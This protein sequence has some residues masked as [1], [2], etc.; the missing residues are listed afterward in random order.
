MVSECNFCGAHM[1]EKADGRVWCP[2]HAA[3]PALLEALE[4]LIEYTKH[5]RTREA[6]EWAKA[7]AA[8]AQAKGG[9]A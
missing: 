8:I 6:P 7:R 9:Q 1:I 3:A 5:R 2:L 4:S